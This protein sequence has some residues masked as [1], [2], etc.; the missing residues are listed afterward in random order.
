MAAGWTRRSF[1][2]EGVTEYPPGPNLQRLRSRLGGAVVLALD[3]SGSMHGDRIGKAI[4]GCRRF[5]DEAV[6][7]GYQ[8]GVILW[9]HDV[10]GVVAPDADP[11]EAYNLLKRAVA[12][13]GNDA[14]PFLALAQRQLMALDVGDR[15][16]A[17]FGDGDLGDRRRA[18]EK[19]SEL[20]NDNIRIL[21]CGLGEASA[22]ELAAISTENSAPRTA[23]AEDLADSIASMA[24]GLTRES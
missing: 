18:Q 1:S 4:K 22:Q 15:V 17:I 24:R 10:E 23:T 3:V 12:A 9:H 21:T 2:S 20:I 11:D 8:V 6:S 13:G 7:A 16:V 5:I 14:V 19:A